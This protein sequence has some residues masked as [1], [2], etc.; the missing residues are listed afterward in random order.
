MAAGEQRLARHQRRPV[1]VQRSGH[2]EAAVERQPVR[3]RGVGV[4][5]RR[6]ARHDQLRSPR[7]AAR[8]RGLPGRGHGVRQRAGVELGRRA[9]ADGQARRSG[10]A[11][12]LRADDDLRAGEGDDLAQLASG[13]LGRHRLRHRPQLPA[14]HVGHEPVGR[15]GQAHGDEVAGRDAA[16]S[17]IT[18]EAVRLP[19]QVAPRQPPG[20]RTSPP[21]DRDH[22]RRARRGGGRRRSEPSAKSGRTPCA[23]ET[24]SHRRLVSAAQCPASGHGARS[25]TA[26][27]DG[28]SVIASRW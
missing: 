27:G 28:L 17:E 18:S 22:V 8:R 9:V 11:L 16:G 15:I 10:K 26:C 6:L 5:E 20:R 3:R 2:H 13:Q 14:R 25:T 7:R 1:V 21:P 12:R 23:Q 19:L 24:R 4:D